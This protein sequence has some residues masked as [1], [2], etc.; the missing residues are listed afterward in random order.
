MMDNADN[1]THNY[2]LTKT[3]LLHLGMSLSLM[4][5]KYVILHVKICKFTSFRFTYIFQSLLT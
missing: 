1:G 4:L 3:V 2:T 5:E